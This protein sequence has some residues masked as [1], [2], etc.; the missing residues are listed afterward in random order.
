MKSYLLLLRQGDL[1]LGQAETRDR[2]RP[3]LLEWCEKLSQEAR[4]ITHESLIHDNRCRVRKSA[5][6]LVIDGP[7]A[8]SRDLVIG[9]LILRAA[10]IGEAARLAGECPSV[11][12]GGEVEVREIEEPPPSSNPL[13]DAG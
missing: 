3:R 6:R 10:N 8:D 2:L 9:L 5:D 11:S 12:M 7:F 1:R 13:D 4:L